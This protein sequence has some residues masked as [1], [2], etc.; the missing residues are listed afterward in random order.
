MVTKESI[1]WNLLR[2]LW[3]RKKFIIITILST[4]IV[5]FI[6][7]TLMPKTYKASLTFIVNEEDTGFNISSLLSDLPLDI[8]SVGN[9]GFDKYLALLGSRR[10][11]DVLIEKLICGKSM[12]KSTLNFCIRNWI[13][14]LK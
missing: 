11:R 13:V 3:P 5:T 7:T 9:K 1:F 8:G 2:I 6:I 12:E 10:V 14:I 4:A